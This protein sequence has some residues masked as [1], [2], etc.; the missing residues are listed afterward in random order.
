VGEE[1]FPDIPVEMSEGLG[2]VSSFFSFNAETVFSMTIVALA[3][4]L[5]LWLATRRMRRYPGR[6]QVAIELVVGAFRDLC[7]QSLG[8]KRGRAFLPLI[9]TLFIFI[10][11]SNLVGLVTPPGLTGREYLAVEPYEDIN[12]NGHRDAGEP[13]EDRNGSGRRELGLWVPHFGEPTKDLAVPLGIALLFAIIIHFTEMR[14]KGVWGYVKGYADPI[15]VMTPINVIGRVAEVFSVSLRLFGN[16][17]GGVVIM[18]VLG[19]L[20]LNL[21]APMGMQLFFGLFVGT[22]QALVYTMLIMTY[23]AVAVS[24]E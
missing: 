16:I 19:S 18:A 8:A 22:V 5:L 20:L 12:G 1:I 11:G 17:F 23:L 15:W 4:S 7:T 9:G 6:L 3:V 21:I 14:Q 13:Y 24:E 10:L 2:R